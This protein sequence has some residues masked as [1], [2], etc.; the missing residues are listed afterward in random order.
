MVVPIKW[1]IIY[2]VFAWMLIKHCGLGTMDWQLYVLMGMIMLATRSKFFEQCYKF[3]SL[4][5]ARRE[6]K[7]KITEHTQTL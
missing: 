5:A 4:R 3:Q 2:M 7:A 6:A 1:F